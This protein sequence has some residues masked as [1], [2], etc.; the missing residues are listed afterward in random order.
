MK[1]RTAENSVYVPVSQILEEIVEEVRFPVEA[2]RFQANGMVVDIPVPMVQTVLKTV[3]GLRLQFIDVVGEIPVVVQRQISMQDQ[4]RAKANEI[5][6]IT[7]GK[8]EF[9]SRK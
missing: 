5:Q 1:Q 8:D 6:G 2:S 4:F 9:F 3:E 7:S